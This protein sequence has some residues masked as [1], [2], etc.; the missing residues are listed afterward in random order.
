MIGKICVSAVAVLMA[1]IPFRAQAAETPGE[2]VQYVDV[3]RYMGKW[4]EIAR[5]PNRFQ[6]GCI[7]S[8]AEYTLRDDGRVSVVNTCVKDE[9]TG[10]TGTARGTA[11]VV[12]T[13]TNAKLKVRF[14]W[15]FSG[16]YWIIQLAEDYSYA[17][18]GHPKKTYLWILSRTPDMDASVYRQITE[19][20][21]TQGYNPD[22]LIK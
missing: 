20:L 9:A 22:M 17:V 16:D 8:T 21:V 3:G 11:W 13:T 2:V 1:L 5:Y 14:F 10:K 15:P 4:Y 6:R 19:K 7:R 12:D 18:V